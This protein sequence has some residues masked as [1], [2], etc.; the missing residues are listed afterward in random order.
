MMLI[1]IS[2]NEYGSHLKCITR[3]YRELFI[4][5]SLAPDAGEIRRDEKLIRVPR[6]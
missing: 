3:L 5:S 6:P 2:R 4:S 1:M